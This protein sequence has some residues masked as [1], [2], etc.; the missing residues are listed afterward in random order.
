MLTRSSESAAAARRKHMHPPPAF[1]SPHAHAALGGAG[2]A[3]GNP[4]VA[5][6]SVGD[7][8][9]T[10]EHFRQ[11][12]LLWCTPFPPASTTS[13]AEATVGALL[14]RR[15]QTTP[16]SSARFLFKRF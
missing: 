12:T 16:L 7:L 2:G 10:R 4:E 13:L 14:L 5:E 3:R 1:K 6:H 15:Q 8:D 11:R 9:V